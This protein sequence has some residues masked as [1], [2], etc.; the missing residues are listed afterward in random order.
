[1]GER[2]WLA[3]M[4]LTLL[5]FVVAV[6]SSGMT[7]VI[8]PEEMEARECLPLHR[9]CHLARA[10]WGTVGLRDF[11]EFQV[12]VQRTPTP[13]QVYEQRRV[14]SGVQIGKAILTSVLIQS[15]FTGTKLHSI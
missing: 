15:A 2:A 5:L 11:G 1:M 10:G 7:S 3:K 8:F 4:Q 12:R 9:C 6:V 13:L 14:S